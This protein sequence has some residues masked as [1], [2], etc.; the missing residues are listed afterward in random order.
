MFS[1]DAPRSAPLTPHFIIIQTTNRQ[2]TSTLLSLGQPGRR[3]V[4]V[5]VLIVGDSEAAVAKSHIAGMNLPK[6]RGVDGRLSVL[7]IENKGVF[8]SMRR[9]RTRRPQVAKDVR[10]L[11]CPW[12]HR[13]GS[14]IHRGCD[15][16]A[17]WSRK[18]CGQRPPF[19]T[20][21]TFIPDTTCRLLLLQPRQ[22]HPTSRESDAVGTGRIASA[23]TDYHSGRSNELR[24]C[25]R[26]A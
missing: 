11:S 9:S 19:G 13:R 5:Q 17:L 16:Q 22:N 24:G 20:L 12:N 7:L 4:D 2:V 18:P 25:G 10:R 23:F 14:V 6:Q 3:N 26:R 8:D 21:P 15:K 1:R